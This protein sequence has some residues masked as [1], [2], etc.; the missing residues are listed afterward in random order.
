VA[1]G[2]AWAPS[3]AQDR[4]MRMMMMRARE[5]MVYWMDSDGG[6]RPALLEVETIRE[7]P[8]YAFA[9]TILPVQWSTYQKIC[10]TLLSAHA[11]RWANF[12]VSTGFN[13]YRPIVA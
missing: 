1:K 10:G 5:N 7:G 9:L 2:R 11:R 6:Q 13:P 8:F 4:A 3:A 12:S